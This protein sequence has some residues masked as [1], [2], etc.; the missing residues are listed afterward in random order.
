MLPPFHLHQLQVRIRMRL[1]L[2]ENLPCDSWSGLSD[3]ACDS[4]RGQ[5]ELHLPREGWEGACSG[6]ATPTRLAPG[7]QDKD[8][9]GRLWQAGHLGSQL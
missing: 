6:P 8:R 7:L 2:M 1:T 9:P 3:R 5:A 4:E